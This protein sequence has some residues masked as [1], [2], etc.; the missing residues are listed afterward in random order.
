MILSEFQ[1]LYDYS[2]QHTEFK[3]IADHSLHILENLEDL[4]NETAPK[5]E[6]LWMG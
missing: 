6:R 3:S 1:K 2:K 4:W 5:A